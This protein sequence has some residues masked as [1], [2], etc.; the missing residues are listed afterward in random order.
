MVASRLSERNKVIAD[1]A[2]CVRNG[3]RT[4]LGTGRK[5][6]GLQIVH[7]RIRRVFG[8]ACERFGSDPIRGV[9]RKFHLFAQDVGKEYAELAAGTPFSMGTASRAGQA[10]C[11]QFKKN[12]ERV[13]FLR[14]RFKKMHGC[15]PTGDVTEAFR[16]IS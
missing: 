13:P 6:H 4:R 12:K 9:G 14:R 7:T 1:S 5:P 16:E 10:V 8:Y 2:A 11:Q 3:R 15:H